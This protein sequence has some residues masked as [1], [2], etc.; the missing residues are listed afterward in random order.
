MI[1]L[2]LYKESLDN[3]TTFENIKNH[4]KTCQ[5]FQQPNKRSSKAK[6]NTLL[7]IFP[8][9]PPPD[10]VLKKPLNP[11]KSFCMKHSQ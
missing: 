10:K 8:K 11:N 6:I 7:A 9:L 2:N 3:L 5:A 1:K 4:L